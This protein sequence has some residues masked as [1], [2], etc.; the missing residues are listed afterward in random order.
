MIRDAETQTLL[1]DTIRR[2][3]LNGT[4]RYITN[5]PEAGIY[6]VMACTSDAKGASNILAFIVERGTPGL[7]LGKPDKKMGQRSAHTSDVIFEHCRVR[8]PI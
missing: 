2:F 6:T 3:V 1:E 4:K 5:A 7:S 8:R